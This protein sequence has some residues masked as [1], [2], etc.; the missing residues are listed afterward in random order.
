MLQGTIINKGLKGLGEFTFAPGKASA[1][2]PVFA[3]S[4]ELGRLPIW[5]HS[6]FPLGPSDIKDIDKLSRCFD[7]VPVI[8]GHMGGINWAAVIELAKANPNLY[9]DLSAMFT[10]MAPRMAIRELPER[11]IFGSDAPYGDP[12]LVRQMVE[13]ITPD[14]SIRNMVMGENISALLAL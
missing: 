9:L 8:M 10:I 5:I 13:R 6:F 11:V 3:A 2:Q 12:L 4:A 1:L 14:K 7:G